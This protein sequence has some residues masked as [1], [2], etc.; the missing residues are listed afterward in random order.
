MTNHWKLQLGQL[1]KEIESLYARELGKEPQLEIFKNIDGGI[2]IDLLERNIEKFLENNRNFDD[3][4][5]CATL[6]SM[7]NSISNSRNYLIKKSK[8]PITSPS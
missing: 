1:R 2:E 3:K 4:V 8:E 7:R 5:V 6:K